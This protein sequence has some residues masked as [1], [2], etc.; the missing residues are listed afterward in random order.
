MEEQW[1]GRVKRWLHE[2]QTDMMTP[3]GP[4]KRKDFLATLA[5]SLFLLKNVR[6]SGNSRFPQPP[7]GILQGLSSNSVLLCEIEIRIWVSPRTTRKIRSELK[8]WMA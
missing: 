2:L 4:E 5:L 7:F 3:A 8:R 6:S 1:R